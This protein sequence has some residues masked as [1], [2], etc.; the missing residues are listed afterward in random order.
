MN[1]FEG[2][3]R[4]ALLL[5]LVVAATTLIYAATYDQFFSVSYLKSASTDGSRRLSGSC[6]PDLARESATQTVEGTTVLLELCFEEAE[7][8]GGAGQFDPDDYLASLKR[9]E[10]YRRAVHSGFEIPES[11]KPW[12]REQAFRRYWQQWRES[13]TLLALGLAFFGALVWAIGWVVRGFMGI[14]R[15]MDKR[16][17]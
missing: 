9:R 6:P 3:R 16:P 1:V 4:V 5:A 2:S 14:P 12:I 13:L 17:D 11:D 15:G 10:S 8:A 7:S